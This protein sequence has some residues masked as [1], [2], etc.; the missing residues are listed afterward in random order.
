MR[1]S[2][3]EDFLILKRVLGLAAVCLAACQAIA[4]TPP[5]FRAEGIVRSSDGS[6]LAGAVVLTHA[7]SVETD[8]LG[9]FRIGLPASDS[10]TITIRR[11]GFESVTFTMVTDSL[12]LQQ[13]EVEL[14]PV[15]REL[16]DVTVRAARTARVP[17]LERF[18]TRRRQMEGIGFFL[19]REEIVRREG[20]PLTSLLSQARG[21]L[22]QENGRG[23]MVLR[24]ARSAQRLRP[25]APYLW[26]DGVRVQGMEIND[27]P[28]R[29]VE[30]VELYASAAGAPSEFSTS[31]A[32]GC[33][34][35]AL[36]TRRPILKSR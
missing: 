11:L 25:C 23:Q 22:I 6:R 5:P 19:T 31:E 13:L 16:D 8:S 29:D 36:W 18:D 34:V 3:Q 27:V 24:M 2:A 28:S 15:A 20:M 33:G 4:Q 17:T 26:I 9:R 7:A 30:A 32:L 1:K 35:V 12:A 21:V 10:T 14:V